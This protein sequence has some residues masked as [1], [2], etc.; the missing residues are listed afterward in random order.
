MEALTAAACALYFSP[1]FQ[2]VSLSVLKQY[3]H[4]VFL[5]LAAAVSGTSNS[6]QLLHQMALLLLTAEA[7]PC[8]AGSCGAGKQQIGG[9]T[10]SRQLP[11]QL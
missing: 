2:T 5:P 6:Q 10:T 1:K 3:V 11:R 8:R 7:W 4:Q 9:C